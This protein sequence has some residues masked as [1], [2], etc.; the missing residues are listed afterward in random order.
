MRLAS[1]GSISRAG[2]RTLLQSVS[3]QDLFQAGRLRLCLHLGGEGSSEGVGWGDLVSSLAPHA[4]CS[5]LLEQPRQARPRA[6][7]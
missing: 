2:R 6:G 1:P 5:P 4:M 7:F 3:L